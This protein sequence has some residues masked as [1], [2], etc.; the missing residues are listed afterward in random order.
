M[1]VIHGIHESLGTA[2]EVIGMSG[3]TEPHNQR[4]TPARIDVASDDANDTVAGTGARKV[5][6]T[7]LNASGVYVLETLSLNGTSKVT[8]V[9]TYSVV[10]L[11]NISEVGSAGQQGTLTVSDGVINI[12]KINPTYGRVIDS[13]HTSS[14]DI[15]LKSLSFSCEH[16]STVKS[17]QVEVCSKVADNMVVV[18]FAFIIDDEKT[19]SYHDLG[20]EAVG[21]QL[22]VRAKSL[23][24]G[25]FRV[26]VSVLYE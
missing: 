8:T 19:M 4:S 11:V 2:Y 20:G 13:V 21:G 7:G 10:Y 14:S 15:S 23:N 5:S 6:F 16:T 26:S 12:Q 1:P 22:F 9:N 25:T 24:S 17:F 3:T 18:L